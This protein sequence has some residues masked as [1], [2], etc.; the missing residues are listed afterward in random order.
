MKILTLLFLVFGITM[1]EACALQYSLSPSL[2]S[3]PM[4]GSV[5][6]QVKE[7]FLVWGDPK[8][9]EENKSAWKFGFV[10]PKATVGAHG[11][12]EAQFSLFPI[13]ILEIGFSESRTER[14]YESRIFNCEIYICKGLMSRSRSF[15]RV[16]LGYESW[17]SL[18][19]VNQSRNSHADTSKPLVDE[20]ENIILKAGGETL[21]STSVFLG[22]KILSDT[23][24]GLAFREL[25]A[26]GTGAKNEAQ[27]MIFR[28]SKLQESLTLGVGRYS[29]DYSVAGLSAVASYSWSWGSSISLF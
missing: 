27:Y 13:S 5:E 6:V 15:A 18:L 14:Y 23:Q 28:V 7:E 21:N 9:D 16:A 2:R 10:Q 8:A 29:S 19:S 20:S 25:K 24:I 11:F 1:R 17:V 12:I 3:Y 4:S 22:Y 26:Q